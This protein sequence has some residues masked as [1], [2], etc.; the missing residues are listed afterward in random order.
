MQLLP[1][2]DPERAEQ[3]LAQGLAPQLPPRLPPAVVGLAK[4]LRAGF[5][6]T[7]LLRTKPQR[8]Q[9]TLTPA[10]HNW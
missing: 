8:G 5:Q 2:M 9:R 10:S 7:E 3:L 4:V 1:H 6:L